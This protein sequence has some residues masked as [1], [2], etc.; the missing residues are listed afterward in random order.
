MGT[1]LKKGTWTARR[2]WRAM[3]PTTLVGLVSFSFTLLAFGTV[4][5]VAALPALIEE[6]PIAAQAGIARAES[7]ANTLGGLPL[8]ERTVDGVVLGGLA[9]AASGGSGQAAGPVAAGSASSADAASVR[10]LLGSLGLTSITGAAASGTAG[11]D[12]S[13]ADAPAADGTGGTGG[14]GGGAPSSPSDGTVP[15]TPTTPE[16]P[17]TPETP[18]EDG[19]QGGSGISEA[20]EQAIYAQLEPYATAL[21]GY[22][23]AVNAQ[24]QLFNDEC[25]DAP[26]ET[27]M[28]HNRSCDMVLD[29]LLAQ[30]LGVRD[31]VAVPNESRY[32][33]LQGDL[34]S[35]YRCLAGYLGSVS[36]AWAYNTCYEDPAEHVDEFMAPINEDLVDG[37]N[38]YLT[39]F[40]RVYEGLQ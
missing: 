37:Q 8:A 13:S 7:A 14:S 6:A 30:Y 35:L 31:S 24:V 28:A 23:D 38:V 17:T 32:K 9:E 2:R 26:L 4:T 20:E 40:L 33:D 16:A 29:Q 27:R 22:V 21:P 25:L 1:T 34:I 3:L 18:G 15:E 39:E 36:T 5:Y 10:S 19:G 11:G 12:G